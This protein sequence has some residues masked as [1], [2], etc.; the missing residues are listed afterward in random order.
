MVV[1]PGPAEDGRISDRSSQISPACAARPG[2][3]VGR[4]SEGSSIRVSSQHQNLGP[5]GGFEVLKTVGN[6]SRSRNGKRDPTRGYAILPGC[7]WHS[8]FLP[9]GRRGRQG[10][11]V[12][13]AR[14]GRWG[15]GRKT[16]SR[17]LQSG[18]PIGPRPAE[19]GPS[20]LGSEACVI[21]VTGYE[22]SPIDPPGA[23]PED[24]TSSAI[25]HRRRPLSLGR[26]SCQGCRQDARLMFAHQPT[27]CIILSASPQV[28]T[29]D[30]G[31]P[32]LTNETG[33][34]EVVP[35]RVFLT[36]GE[37]ASDGT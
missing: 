22:P 35:S 37:Y 5:R 19:M 9:R 6:Q 18:F 14:D 1:A 28:A 10:R 2:R 24:Q 23:G 26:M 34:A 36:D 8:S 20:Y 3:G 13:T 31:M 33:S 15:K 27:G 32:L 17:L 4:P 11:K 21:L 7:R 29:E 12:T 25:S 16:G 30:E